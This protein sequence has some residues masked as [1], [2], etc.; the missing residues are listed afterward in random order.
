VRARKETG[1]LQR[2]IVW[3]DATELE[4]LHAYRH[5]D[6]AAEHRRRWTAVYHGN[7]RQKV[8]TS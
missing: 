5:R 3:A 4:R 6:I 2:W 7:D 8:A 1:G